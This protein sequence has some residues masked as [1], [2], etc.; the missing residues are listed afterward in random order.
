MKHL[1]LKLLSE[2]VV[3]RRKAKQLTQVQISKLTGI[4][5]TLLS[6]LESQDY[7]PS[8]DQL[9]ALS[10]VDRQIVGVAG[11]DIRADIGSDEEALLEKDPLVARLAVGSGA[12]RM[13]MVE[14]QSADIPRIRPAAQGLDEAVG[15]AGDAAQVDMAVGRDVADR[16]VGGN[17]GQG[18]HLE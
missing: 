6:R 15:H 3:S 12:F 9:L 13:E 5:R 11:V 14:L 7:T 8:V 17:E 1:S 4:N 10:E 18:L 2:T 16:L